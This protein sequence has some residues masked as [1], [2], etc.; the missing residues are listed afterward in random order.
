MGQIDVFHDV[1]CKLDAV[2]IEHRAY[3]YARLSRAVG[4][5]GHAME[6]GR[7]VVIIVPVHQSDVHLLALELALQG[8]R[9]FQTGIART[10][11][12]DSLHCNHFFQAR[13]ALPRMPSISLRLAQDSLL[14]R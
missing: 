11:D 6:K 10:H 4:A 2:L 8:E 3:E 14:E 7:R 12:Y 9:A 5:Q 1:F 13:R